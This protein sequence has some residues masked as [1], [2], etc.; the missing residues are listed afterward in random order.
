MNHS[1][2][3]IIS[4]FSV[5]IFLL[6]VSC[7]SSSDLVSSVS[8]LGE[9]DNSSI[10]VSTEHSV[11]EVT[12]DIPN[13][14]LPQSDDESGSESVSSNDSSTEETCKHVFIEKTVAATCTEN[15]YTDKIC[16]KCNYTYRSENFEA[17]HNSIKYVCD[18]CGA[19]NKEADKLWALSAWIAKFGAPNGKGNIMCYP[20]DDSP[21]TIANY[22]DDRRLFIDGSDYEKDEYFSVFVEDYDFCTVNYS[23]GRTSGSFEIKNSAL[24]SAE[25][26]VFDDFYTPEE[27]PMD[28]DEFAT[29]CA[30]RIDYYMLRA[31]NEIL[32]PKTGIKLKD[33]GFTKYE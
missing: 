1:M 17:Y 12:P 3:R 32:Y 22:L 30:Q 7:R 29:L 33:L 2:K 26:V 18:R 24:S 14:D 10:P 8:S 21:I 16:E 6:L 11:E 20:A 5:F 23:I 28:C 25:K 31:Q 15:G 4:L 9:I 13:S 27:D 19:L